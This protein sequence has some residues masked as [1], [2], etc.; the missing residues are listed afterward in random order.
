MRCLFGSMLVAAIATVACP[1]SARPQDAADTPAPVG[2][3]AAEQARFELK[4]GDRVVFIGNTFFEREGRYGYIETMLTTRYPGKRITFRNLGW[5]GDT[6]WGES[7]GYFEPEKGYQ[8]LIDLVAELKPTVIFL[9]YGNNEAFAGK[10]GLAPFIKQYNKFLDDLEKFTKRIVLLGCLAPEE[11]SPPLPD[12]SRYT[13]SVAGCNEA[14][15]AIASERQH[16][17]FSIEISQ[18][19]HQGGHATDGVHLT[20]G[21][22]R[23]VADRLV[24]YIVPTAKT[25]ASPNMEHAERIRMA[26]VAKNQLFFYRW[27]PQNTT[28][29]LGFRKHEQG[30][31]AKEIAQFDPLIAAKE[32][33]IFK[34]AQPVAH[35][36]EL[37]RVKE[38][39]KGGDKRDANEKGDK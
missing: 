33:E 28:Y 24:K 29:L 25:Q 13:T 12:L 38:D 21:G 16:H 23:A 5:S 18:L 17:F 37:I 35:K 3:A 31:N 39:R 7:R 10:E 11:Q 20:G 32:E 1:G 27:R 2:R 4:D 34:L 15:K 22:Y 6:V 8:N 9:A 36:Y 19:D 14:I 26:I 30:Q